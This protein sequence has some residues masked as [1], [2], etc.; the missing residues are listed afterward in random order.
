VA[1]PA[2]TEVFAELT[3]K[4]IVMPSMATGVDK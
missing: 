3:D 2:I 1:L 4:S